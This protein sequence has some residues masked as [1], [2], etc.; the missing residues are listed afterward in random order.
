VRALV[1]LLAVGC[2]ADHHGSPAVDA[3]PI[4]P[5]A[6]LNFCDAAVDSAHVTVIDAGTTT[7]YARIHAGALILSGP[8]APVN[9]IPMTIQLMFTDA[10]H[11]STNDGFDCIAPDYAGCP[12]TGA[13]AR[14]EAIPYGAELGTHPV[15]F[16]S[17]THAGLDAHGTVTIDAIIRPIDAAPGNIR[18][19]VTT[20]SGADSVSGTFEN[21]F[22]LLSATI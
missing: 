14:T 22:C 19:S 12:L 21:N 1:L 7:T 13:L 9:G 5:D 8:V 18:G 4:L 16:D 3:P 11:I 6:D 15:T 2:G 20:T 17:L 10:D